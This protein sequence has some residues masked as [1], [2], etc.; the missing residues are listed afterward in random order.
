MPGSGGLRALAVAIVAFSL[1]AAGPA[2]AKRRFVPR[3]FKTIQKAIDASAPGDT[4]WVRAGVYHGPFVLEQ[5]LTLFGEGGPDSTFLDGGDS[6][7]VL[8]VEG[9]QGG[10]IIGFGIR[11]GKATGGGGV[12]CV[13]DSSFQ[14]RDCEFEANWDAAIGLWGCQ[15]VGIIGNIVHDNRGSGIRANQSSLIV[16]SCEF[17]GNLGYDGGAISLV[18]SQIVVTIR[19]CK[20]ENNRADGSTGGAVNLADSSEA[21][22]ASCTFTGNSSAVAGGAVAAMNGSKSNLSRCRF[23]RNHAGTGGAVHSDVSGVLIGGCIFDQNQA[24]A[25]GAAIGVQ[26]RVMAN[27]NPIYQN[28]TFYKNTVTGSGATIFAINVSPEIRKNIF[29]VTKDQLAVG[30]LESSPL[31]DCNLIWDPT[32][33]AIGALPSGN[34][35]VGDPLFCDPD[36]RDFRMR[37]LSPA[38]RALCGPVGANSDKP[39]CRSFQLQ[40]AR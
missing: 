13:R 40:P 4:V 30:G 35:L 19:E 12:Q 21:S 39:G 14:I 11:H 17:R 15:T 23:E 20:F 27:V 26:G 6:T 1:L 2:H 29:V 18:Q 16:Q 31:Y 38:L 25:A 9:V 36:K 34:T 8:H 7:R 33:G 22:F 24:S 28:N 32:G 3:E 5:S 10:G 37:D